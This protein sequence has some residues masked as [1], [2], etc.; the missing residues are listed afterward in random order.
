MSRWP[1]FTTGTRPR[2]GGMTRPQGYRISVPASLKSLVTASSAEWRNATNTHIRSTFARAT[3]VPV[4]SGVH[5][6]G[7]L[8]PSEL[9]KS[10]LARVTARIMQAGLDMYLEGMSRIN[11]S[12]S[13]GWSPTG[14]FIDPGKSTGVSV[15][16]LSEK[17]Q[18]EW[19][20]RSDC[21]VS[22]LRHVPRKI[23]EQREMK[24]FAPSFFI[25]S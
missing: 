14:T 20:C 22:R 13:L 24:G 25:H 8:R 16:T 9:A 1:R 19:L 18:V 2:R 17:M 15:R 12:M 4:P 3:I 10:V 23:S 11:F 7:H 6:P 21:V 5:L